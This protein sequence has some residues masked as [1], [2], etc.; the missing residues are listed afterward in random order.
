MNRI[1]LFDL[2]CDFGNRTL[3]TLFISIGFIMQIDIF[4]LWQSTTQ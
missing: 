1:L 3:F 4:Y 2:N